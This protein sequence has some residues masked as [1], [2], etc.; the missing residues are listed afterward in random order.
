[1]LKKQILTILEDFPSEIRK[2]ILVLLDY[3][4]GKGIDII[5]WIES[6]YNDSQSE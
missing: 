6:F 3:K 4:S 5:K 1:M 2:M